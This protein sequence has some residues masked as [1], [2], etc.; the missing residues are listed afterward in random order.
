LDDFWAKAAA[1]E[2]T[3][4]DAFFALMCSAYMVRGVYYRRPGLDAAVAA[5]V[6]RLDR[7]LINLPLPAAQ[8]ENA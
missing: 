3:L 1:P 6:E 8:P 4:R 7:G 5:T 2:Q